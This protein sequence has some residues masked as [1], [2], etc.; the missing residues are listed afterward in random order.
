MTN[1][2]V[3]ENEL[4]RMKYKFGPSIVFYCISIKNG[5]VISDFYKCKQLTNA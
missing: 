5:T 1:R 4:E 3:S 2:S